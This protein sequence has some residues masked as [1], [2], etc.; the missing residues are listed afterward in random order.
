MNSKAELTSKLAEIMSAGE[1]ITDAKVVHGLLEEVSALQHQITQQKAEIDTLKRDA[2]SDHLT[3]LANRRVLEKEVERAVAS[4]QRYNRSH[5][6]LFVDLN[7]FKQ[8]ND[9]LGHA[10]G[11]DV[12]KHVS[13]LLE[14]NTRPT[15]VVAR[16]GGDEF[17]ILM[18]EL[19]YESDME[20]RAVS[21]ADILAATPCMYEGRTIQISATVGGHFFDGKHD[22]ESVL[23]RADEDM[24]AKKPKNHYR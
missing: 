13:H 19:E 18:M 1:A 8:I 11:D 9:R 21:L 3:G 17:C 5:A 23:R 6:L 10:A 4:A 12:L 7:G 2:M 15:D 14:Q 20:A 22:A 16:L 24:Y